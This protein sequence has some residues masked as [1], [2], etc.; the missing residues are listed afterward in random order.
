MPSSDLSRD[1]LLERLGDFRILREVGQGGMG[2]VYEAEQESLGR[3][4]ALKVLPRQALLKGTY[5]ERFRREAK[6]AARLHH[7][8][9]VPVFGTGEA[10][11][12]PFYAMQ[13]IRGEGLDK[14]LDDLRRLRRQPAPDTAASGEASAAA[15]LLT[16]RFSLADAAT[17][18][19]P[20]SGTPSGS[21]SALSASGPHADYHRGVARVG[22]QV[23]EALAYAHRQ[24]IL[25]RD[26][27][28]SNLLLDQQ[29]TVWVTDFG[30][31]KA[32][33]ADDLTQTGDI[34]G[35]LRFMAPER[36]DGKSLPQSDVYALG[37]TLYELLTLR[38]AFDDANKGRLIDKV[39][40]EPPAPP[41]R[42]D[43][44]LPRDLET[45][46]LKCLAKDPAERYA[47]AEAL[48]EDLR[49]FLADRPIQARRTPWQE[50]T[51]RWCRRNP[52]LAGSL[53][54]VALLLLV[55]A[56]GASVM[57]L[58]LGTAL[59]Q[60]EQDRDKAEEAVRE[61]KKQLFAAHLAEAKARRFSGRPGQRFGTLESI[62]K[63][64]A[65]ARELK[66]PAATFDELRDLAIAA[67]ALPDVG[68]FKT[69]DGWPEGSV[70][71]A[72]DP[73]ALRWYARADQQGNLTV[74]QTEDD[75]ELA[76]LPGL[77]KKRSHLFGLDGRTLYLHDEA[78][79]FLK[80]WTLGGPEPVKL[81]PIP[82][83]YQGMYLSEDG[84][85]LL[86]LYRGAGKTRAR[87]YE[88]P[89]G[90]KCF[91]HELRNDTILRTDLGR[92]GR[93]L[94][95]LYSVKEGTHVEVYDL[96]TGQRCFQRLLLHDDLWRRRWN[97]ALSPDG[98]WLATHPDGVIGAPARNKVLIFDLDTGK[99]AREL[100]HP[101][102]VM[103]P[104]WHPDSTTLAVGLW[105]TGEIRLWDV[106]SG[107]LLRVCRELKGGE[108]YLMMSSSGQLLAGQSGWWGGQVFW[109]PHTGKPLLR[110]P[111]A[112]DLPY[113]TR[114]GRLC[115]YRLAEGKITLNIAQPSPVLRT[116]VPAP[117][118][119]P[120]ND[121]RVVAI[122]P[123]GRLLALGH[124]QGVSLFDL[125]RGLEVG[126]LDLGL[127]RTVRFDP[128]SGD[129]LTCGV[130]GVFRWPV[131]RDADRPE[132]IAVGPPQRLRPP[133]LGGNH[134]IAVS[135]DGKK[136]AAAESSRAVVLS[137]DG[138]KLPIVLGPLQDVRGITISPD[139][140]WVVTHRF[141][142]S[143]VK[144]W[145]AATGKL[146]V[147]SKDI[148]MP[149]SRDSR[150]IT[151]GRRRWEVG[152]WREAPRLTNAD[153]PNALA[154]SPDERYFLADMQVARA[155]VDSA[156]GRTVA[157]L[158][159]PD[160]GR[161]WHAAFSPDGAQLIYSS[162]D[163]FVVYVWDLRKLRHY[164]AELGLDWDAPAYPAAPESSAPYATAPLQVQISGM[165]L[166]RDVKKY[167][168]HQRSQALQTLKTRPG[169]PQAN[170]QLGRIL[171]SEGRT[172]EAHHHLGNVLAANP[173]HETARYWRGQA[174][175]RLQR[176]DEAAADATRLLKQ[177]ADQPEVRH[178]RAEAYGHLK[179]YT[180][181]IADLTAAL[182]RSPGSWI[183]LELRASCYQARGENDKAR[184]DREKA[185]S[186]IAS[187]STL[188]LNNAAW[189]MVT[190]SA[191]LR[192]PVRA[193]R[194]I[195]EVIRREPNNAL[196]LNTF[197]VVLYR[198]GD[199]KKAL[200]TLEKSLAAGKG[201]SDAF[202]LFF[203]ALCHARLG[204]P[205]KAND[206]FDRAVKWV[207][208]QK[209]LPAHYIQELKAFRAEAEAEL[210][211]P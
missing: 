151:N 168:D 12:V 180:E 152:S 115:G 8:N 158:E 165:D 10:D 65:L 54:T 7:T 173:D 29:G 55:I 86:V 63:A 114:D 190:G 191:E 95:V 126:H 9:I 23:A 58:R 73:V 182:S 92:D 185:T 13:F 20:P 133:L 97:S 210:R 202:D 163:D 149:F 108:P 87:G 38:P 112:Y 4:V 2:V 116:L 50:R 69:W 5:V 59:D 103:S 82:G 98:R 188:A 206:C 174:A 120:L 132:I 39:L 72:F 146:A 35:T 21:C 157:T 166:A 66:M 196:Y 154:F 127:N 200:A 36:F 161:T 111:G 90:R 60:S 74:R 203:L 40:H 78:D 125:T 49:R 122:H 17:A 160:P 46:V 159:P 77:G 153:G 179:K 33:G 57:A 106:P 52:A 193:L 44:H 128:S 143:E 64:V 71:L 192:N 130:L 28:P 204:E 189:E 67:L 24:G 142:T 37:A 175:L 167:N 104:A 83:S 141:G 85:R 91:E 211:A 207:E 61:G 1:A 139:G 76:R 107:K 140:R 43:A 181:A 93:R 75:K 96:A 131:R 205:A 41:R 30:L 123:D 34:V 51:W 209:N 56:V 14:V 109:H 70:S 177:G 169:D 99:L 81:D 100:M 84:R 183:Y 195:E 186:A 15:G 110:I 134:D 170:L 184:A 62:R 42:L 198:K 155:L 197:G 31:A 172:K 156:T 89:G 178:L 138:A 32:E 101:G 113:A 11:G 68:E 124:S 45:V 187:A 3:H 171:L 79:G 118:G 121:C 144:V 26:V 16:G 137:S 88:L 145:D 48:A 176:W 105:N 25:H 119:K 129:L 53:S 208:A 19:A 47:S 117:A 94:L 194:L 199:Y 162:L 150:W 164:L 80:R 135:A 147:E 6:A 148:A 18:E 102:N 201:A 27:K 22:L 136:I